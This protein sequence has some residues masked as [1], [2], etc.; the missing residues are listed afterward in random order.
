MP[1]HF[2]LFL[3]VILCG[4]AS[5]QTRKPADSTLAGSVLSRLEAIVTETDTSM[6]FEKAFVRSTELLGELI[7]YSDKGSETAFSEVALKRRLFRLMVLC[8]NESQRKALWPYLRKND[9]LA[10]ELSRIVLFG[11][12]KDEADDLP[13]VFTLLDKLRETRGD[14]LNDLAA[15]TTAVC[16]VHDR[17]ITRRMNENDVRSPDPYA[18]WDYF[19]GN[20][21]RMYFGLRDV[22]T[23]LLLFVVDTTAGIDEMTW[24]LNKFPKDPNIGARFFE[25]NYD[26]E[27]VRS[28]A[29]KQVTKNGYNLPNIQKYGG[30]CIDQAYYA[31]QVG[32]SMGIP[33]GIALAL[34]GEVGH[35]WVG[36]LQSQGKRG[37]WNFN[38]GRYPEYQGLAGAVENPQ[39]GE[40]IPDAVVAISAEMILLPPA[41]R[42]YAI[43]CTDAAEYLILQDEKSLNIPTTA[44]VNV[45]NLR[46]QP[47]VNNSDTQLAFCEMAVTA[48]PACIRAW[49]LVINRAENGKLT[50]P[51]KRKWA[52][53]LTKTCGKKYPDFTFAILRPMVKTVE[54]VKEQDRIWNAAFAMFNNRP[55]LAAA[56]RMEQAAMWEKAG[57]PRAAGQCYEDIINRFTT[58]GP[59]VLDALAKC[60]DALIASRMPDKVLALYRNTWGKIPEPQGLAGPFSRMSNWYRVGDL[61]ANKLREAGKHNEAGLV[62]QKIEGR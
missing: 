1:R 48:N 21:K 50:L 20:E 44:P 28:G 62:V 22:P 36:F 60:E 7:A 17:Q 45:S 49:E 9:K 5:A 4:T 6:D 37:W 43:A 42:E 31:T 55:D 14:K 26:F 30:V 2:I 58:D 19:A 25:I 53:L 18:I 41:Q 54:D 13:Q 23:E 52:D 11:K 57:N 32:K 15:L 51:D 59:F 8:E 27:H 40:M 10:R 29:T 56:V 16:V 33:T 35:A 38:A 3:I 12:K 39:T 46:K 47:R 61:Y 34:G 24:A